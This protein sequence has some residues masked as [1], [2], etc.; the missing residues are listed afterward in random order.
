MSCWTAFERRIYLPWPVGSR[1]NLVSACA[2]VIPA[3][4]AGY[5]AVF[6]EAWIARG[7]NAAATRT[8]ST[9]LLGWWSR[10]STM[11]RQRSGWQG[12]PEP[13]RHVESGAQHSALE[14]QPLERSKAPG[15][16]EEI[17]PRSG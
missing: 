4:D 17:C 10:P 7:T 16:P 1:R 8:A 2:C 6:K 3:A 13:L 12:R 5:L 15:A 9:P 11:T 14:C